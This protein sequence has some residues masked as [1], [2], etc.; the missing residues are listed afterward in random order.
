[1]I[2]RK[3]HYVEIKIIDSTC[4]CNALWSPG[5]VSLTK[6]RTSSVKPSIKGEKGHTHKYLVLHNGGK[7]L[8][9]WMCDHLFSNTDKG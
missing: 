9:L 8:K 4:Q 7:C 3:A 6:L 1:M 2:S 5:L